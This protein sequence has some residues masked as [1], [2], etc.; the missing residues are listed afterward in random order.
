MLD[1]EGNEIGRGRDTPAHFKV[2]NYENSNSDLFTKSQLERV[3]G[4]VR[5]ARDHLFAVQ[6]YLA[7]AGFECLRVDDTVAEV[8]VLLS[9]WSG[10]NHSSRIETVPAYVDA[11]R[12]YRRGCGRTY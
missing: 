9:D 6:F 8:S 5:A 12:A 1:R 7:D 3:T 11:A 4:S 2:H 10:R